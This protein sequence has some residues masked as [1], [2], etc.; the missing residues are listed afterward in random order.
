MQGHLCRHMLLRLHLEVGR[1]HPRLDRAE[2]ILD[3]LTPQGDF[4]GMVVRAAFG[5]A[6]GW[7]RA[8]NAEC[9]APSQWYT[10]L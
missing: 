6:L 4:P 5:H 9:D 10:W 7:L 1:T 3:R 8:P 2:R